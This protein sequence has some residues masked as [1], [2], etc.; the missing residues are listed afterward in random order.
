MLPLILQKT[1]K[2]KASETT[3]ITDCIE[4]FGENGTDYYVAIENADQKTIYQATGNSWDVY[5]R[6][7]K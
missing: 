7:D 4:L 6:T 5:K 2:D 3:W 1:L